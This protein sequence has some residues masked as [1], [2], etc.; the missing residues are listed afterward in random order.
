MVLET[1]D[2]GPLGPEDVEVAVENCGLCHSDLSVFINEWGIS[3]FPAILGHEV[4]GR[5]TA[6]GS[7]AKGLT[8]GQHVGVGWNSGSCMHCRQCLSGSQHLCP[9][10]QPTIVG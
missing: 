8:I 1:V 6:L 2:L 7:N 9:Q 3:Q 5:V 4:I 10:V